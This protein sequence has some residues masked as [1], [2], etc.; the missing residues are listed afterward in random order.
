[1]PKAR[2]SAS[3]S[4]QFRHQNTL[5]D[6]ILAT[7]PLRERTKKRKSQSADNGDG[8]GDGYI[9]SKSSRKILR[10]GRELV[11]EEQQAPS[12]AADNTSTA[13]TFESRFG[14]SGDPEDDGKFGDDEGWGDEEEET[15]EEAVGLR[16][17]SCW[18][19]LT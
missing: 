5:E 19:L 11:Q 9:D 7:G 17:L 6:D 3:G 1:M 16:C 14:G 8:D 18:T 2:D 12:I 10:I 4:V 13:F 15:V